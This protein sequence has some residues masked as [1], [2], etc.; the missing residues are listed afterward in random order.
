MTEA[1]KVK[2]LVDDYDN[3]LINYIEDGFDRKAAAKQ[4]AQ[5]AVDEILESN[6]TLINC[7]SNEFN[8]AYYIKM[9]I[10]INKL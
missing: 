8:Y 3:L 9:Q 7:D 6:P 1:Q 10:E 5:I 4:C 2:E